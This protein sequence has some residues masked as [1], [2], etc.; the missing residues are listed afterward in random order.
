[1]KSSKND[2]FVY[3]IW[4]KI[5][6]LYFVMFFSSIIV[7][8][9]ASFPDIGFPCYFNKLV[10]YSAMKLSEKNMARYIT[11]TLFLEEA[12]M[13]FYITFSFVTDF[14]SAIYFVMAAIAVSRA[15]K[16]V[17]GLTVLSQWIGSV[18]S[19]SIVYLGLLKLW[20]IQLFIH[21]LSY[22]HIYLAAFIYAIHFILAFIY[23]QFYITHAETTW[24]IKMAEKNVPKDTLLSKLIVY[25]KPL[26][27]NLHL[28]C[29]AL[30]M[31]VFCL[32]FMMAIGNSFYV[33]VSDIV[34]GSINLFLSLNVVWYLCTELWLHKYQKYQFGFHAG[35]LISSIILMMPLVRYE[36]I[37]MAVNLHTLVAINISIIPILATVAAIV[38]LAR[39]LVQN[40]K[41]KY[42][43]VTQEDKLNLTK[44]HKGQYGSTSQKSSIMVEESD[45]ESVF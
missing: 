42:V 24:S 15:K 31:L 37:F 21:V 32:S 29:L 2:I 13:F 39:I 28:T 7:P 36:A 11:P 12:E 18:G 41:A 22:K 38:R 20:S 1:M 25:F 45:E 26:T 8:I 30:E 4:L 17:S 40:K 14:A 16:N 9:T 6:C 3:G 5:L 27:M 43:P 23:M 19:P 10:D 35:V 33:F 34:I 44:T